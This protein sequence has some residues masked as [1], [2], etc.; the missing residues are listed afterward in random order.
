MRIWQKQSFE[1][2]LQLQAGHS[3]CSVVAVVAAAAA[4][5]AGVAGDQTEKV[6]GCFFTTVIAKNIAKLGSFH[7][8]LQK[9]SQ[10]EK[11][12]DSSTLLLHFCHRY[13]LSFPSSTK[14]H[15]LVEKQM[16]ERD[17]W[18]KCLLSSDYRRTHCCSPICCIAT[19]WISASCHIL[20]NFEIIFGSF[21][22]K[23]TKSYES[24][25]L[26]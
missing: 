15:F 5:A 8:F 1:I 4:V 9:W 7:C 16:R 20:S 2:L 12:K 23:I 14:Q 6:F 18:T 24:R 19:S 21:F 17:C 3:F 11:T 10:W 26:G 13:F 22:R 25:I